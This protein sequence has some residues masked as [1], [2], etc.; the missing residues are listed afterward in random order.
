MELFYVALF[1]LQ[2]VLAA[3]LQF[4]ARASP[5]RRDAAAAGPEFAAFSNN[6][7]AVYCLAMAGDW[8]QGPYVYAL[9]QHYGFGRGDIGRLFIAGFG[10]SMI[11]GT[12]VGGAADRHGR[13]RAALTYVVCYTLGCF[14]KHFASFWVLFV[15]RIFCGIATS[16]L[17]SAFEA[18]LVA[19]HS[20]RGFAPDLL[21][22]V[23]SRAV[24]LGNGLCAIV[25]GLVA[26]AL[27][28]TLEL[29]PVVPF[30]TA[31][32]VLL[33]C[34]AIVW[35]TWPENYGSAAGG[36]V[37]GAG[38]AATSASAGLAETVDN[39]RRAGR[40]I[41]S[42][43]KIAL[44][45]AMQALFEG[46]MYTFVFLWTPA[47]APGGERIPHGMVFA[48]FM[49]SCMVGSAGAGRLLAHGSRH[50]PERY[51]QGVFVAAAACLAVPVL[52]HRGDA[53]LAAPG[54]GIALAGRL[55]LIAFCA[56]EGL[57]GVFWPSM[58]AMRAAY[59]P[60]ELRATLINAFRIPLNLFVCVVL[61]NVS[62]FP[63]GAM[64]G[65]CAAFLLV[66]AACQRRLAAIIMVEAAG[67]HFEEDAAPLK[68]LGGKAGAGGE[69]GAEVA[70]SH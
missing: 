47:L 57:V 27:V 32:V 21:G 36:A 51:M 6:Y 70:A 67:T 25:A 55:Q 2:A 26:H 45:G 61:Y 19:E 9:Y 68:A 4:G 17:Y 41:A 18:W 44:L 54:A 5:G 63:L 64:F 35:T 65:M 37:V 20:R 59:V 38:T 28:E 15:G 43:P 40:L 31:A 13:R 1:G 14:T 62:A 58:M 69:G 49:V 60:E 39:F 30:D 7:L 52:Y 16:L 23:F 22:G 48:C 3:A 29:G 66:C 10:S 8:L 53:P 24:F 11:F 42:D 50:R 56:F 46:S 12:V 33:T 34:G